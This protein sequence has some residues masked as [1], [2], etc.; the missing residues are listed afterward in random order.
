MKRILGCGL[1]LMSGS[2]LT[3]GLLMPPGAYAA[4]S[5]IQTCTASTPDM[6]FNTNL[7]AG[8]TSATTITVTCTWNAGTGNAGQTVTIGLG[9]G[10]SGSESQRKLKSGSNVLTYNLYQTTAYTPYWG[11][12]INAATLTVK[13]NDNHTYPI[14]VYGRIDNTPANLA[15]PPGTYTDP[16]ILVNLSWP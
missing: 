12:A 7:I 2:L 5:T 1:R 13:P 8:V 15:A 6:T 9:A 14:T 10:T 16:A 4:S 11:S 3:L